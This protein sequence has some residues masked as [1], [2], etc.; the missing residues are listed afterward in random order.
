M[1]TNQM[2]DSDKILYVKTQILA[3]AE[4]LVMLN[5]MERELRGPNTTLDYVLGRLKEVR[6]NL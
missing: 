3:L 6:E 4:V 5:K 1:K 2:T